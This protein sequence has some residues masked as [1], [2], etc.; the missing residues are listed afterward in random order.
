MFK[1]IYIVAIA[2]FIMCC[3]SIYASD[4]DL[5]IYTFQTIKD[6]VANIPLGFNTL[7]KSYWGS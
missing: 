3:N 4:N 2:A 1:N 6:N 5:G 7:S